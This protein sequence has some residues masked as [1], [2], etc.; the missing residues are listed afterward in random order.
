MR[1]RRM[2]LLL[3]MAALGLAG[4]WLS[5]RPPTPGEPTQAATGV[6][7]ESASRSDSESAAAALAKSASA[8]STSAAKVTDAAANTAASSTATG[9]PLLQADV[10]PGEALRML[11][12]CGELAW[13]DPTES[14]EQQWRWLGD[15]V[16]ELERARYIEARAWA[17]ERCG[18]WALVPE[19]DRAVALRT[20]LVERARQSTDLS[21]RLRAL[22]GM[23]GALEI[24]AAQ[25]VAI[26]QLLEQALLAGRPEL[27]A[28]IGRVLG[29]SEV[30]RADL[31]GPYA[32]GG[33]ISL[34]SLLG[35]DLGAPCG[36]DSD[37]LRRN[38]A[39]RGYCGYPDYETLLFDAYHGSRARELIQ[40][41]R[42]ELLRRIRAGEVV[43]LFDP[44]PLP[45]PPPKP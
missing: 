26:R 43:G 44:L 10:A 33:A 16:A 31:L 1:R 17:V 12:W 41:H 14:I 38:C 2:G 8:T 6:P 21:D 7:V 40:A 23:R 3:S 27:L 22:H 5:L 45:L 13:S 32:G 20:Q 39:L 35:C 34:F 36:A 37:A 42:T 4:W 29:A 25:A 9:D 24:D 30:A 15:G 11:Q 18:D 19:S 28:D